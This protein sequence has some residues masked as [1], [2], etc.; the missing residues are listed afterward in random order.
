MLWLVKTAGQLSLVGRE[1]QAVLLG[2]Q[3]GPHGQVFFFENVVD[4][5]LIL[6]E[7]LL[8]VLSLA[9][10]L[11]RRVRSVDNPAPFETL[12]E[13]PQKVGCHSLLL[14]DRYIRFLVLREIVPYHFGGP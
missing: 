9:F 3:T 13:L 10:N 12:S 11:G 7:H 4:E 8:E 6:T 5:F 14:F 1:G 2:F